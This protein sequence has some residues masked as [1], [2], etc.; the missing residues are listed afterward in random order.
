MSL[1]V[2][3]NNS[4]VRREQGFAVYELSNSEVKLAIVPELGAKIISLKNVRTG[5]EWM[6]HPHGELKLFHNPPGD[7]FS[8]SPLAGV[9]ECL[10]TIAPCAWHGRELPDHG[11]V[12]SAEWDVDENAWKKGVLKTQIRLE[13]SPFDFERTIELEGNT[14]RLNYRLSNRST[15]PEEFL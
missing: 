4:V 15:A 7:D 1:K 10:P 11:E 9:D 2:L 12:W 13:I 6:W 14:I 8:R 3:T 5:R